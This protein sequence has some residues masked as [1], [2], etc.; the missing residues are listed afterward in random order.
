[1]YEYYKDM[2]LR[3]ALRRKDLHITQKALSQKLDISN[4]HLSAIEHGKAVPS[5][6]T[7]VNLCDVLGVSPNYLLYGSL[8]HGNISNN[9]IDSLS[10]VAPEDLP[11]IQEII[12]IYVAKNKGKGNL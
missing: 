12:N 1:M 5:F 6:S 2:G 11:I 8:H 7:F 4:N 9:I 10:L 3:I